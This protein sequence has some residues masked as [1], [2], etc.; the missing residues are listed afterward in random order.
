MSENQL[1]Q[2]P[3]QDSL[4][5]TTPP[6]S[7]NLCRCSHKLNRY[8]YTP[9]RD[10]KVEVKMIDH[11]HTLE[12]KTIDESYIYSLTSLISY[13]KEMYTDIRNGNLDEIDLKLGPILKKGTK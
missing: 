12:S 9:Y 11:A 5:I 4:E 10:D 2:Q 1:S 7:T 8:Q 3:S 13:L 6:N